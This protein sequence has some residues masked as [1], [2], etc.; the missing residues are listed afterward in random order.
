MYGSDEPS[1]LSCSHLLTS[2]LFELGSEGISSTSEGISSTSL[3]SHNISYSLSSGSD[4]MFLVLT[5]VYALFPNYDSIGTEEALLAA[6]LS[7][8]TRFNFFI[9]AP[10]VICLKILLTSTGEVC[11]N[12]NLICSSRC[13][14]F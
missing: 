2:I 3:I 12:M 11:L 6:V 7:R 9:N 4:G 10:E 5:V 8:S 14:G 1:N 13:S